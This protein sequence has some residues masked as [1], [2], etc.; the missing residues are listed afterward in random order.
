[1]S[2]GDSMAWLHSRVW[3]LPKEE[4]GEWWHRALRSYG[5][6]LG[7]PSDPPGRPS[8]LLPLDHFVA[9]LQRL[10]GLQRRGIHPTT[11]WLSSTVSPTSTFLATMKCPRR[12]AY[13]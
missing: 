6:S 2:D 4:L 3:T 10:A 12:T 9:G 13:V 1:M 5:T 7:A 8:P 11:D